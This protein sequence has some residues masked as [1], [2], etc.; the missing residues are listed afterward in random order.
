VSA[1]CNTCGDRLFSFEQAHCT[2]CRTAANARTPQDVLRSI[3]PRRW[4]SIPLAF[5]CIALAAA[6]LLAVPS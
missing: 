4:L 2:P 1:R 5:A 6:L 3:Q